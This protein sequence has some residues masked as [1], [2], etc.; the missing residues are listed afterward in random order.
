MMKC[1]YLSAVE[2]NSRRRYANPAAHATMR[3][4]PR[5]LTTSGIAPPAAAHPGSWA[6]AASK[7]PSRD[8]M[9]TTN[10]DDMVMY[11]MVL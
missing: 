9:A 7:K 6:A 10:T 1:A 11:I 4:P 5:V 8:R 2:P 3:S